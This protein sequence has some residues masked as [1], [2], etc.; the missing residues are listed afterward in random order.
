MV[1]RKAISSRV[2]LSAAIVVLLV[3]LV[4]LAVIFVRLQRPPLELRPDPG[5]MQWIR[6]LYG[7]GP[8]ADEQFHRP[9]SVAIGP[10][11]RIY[12]A[13]PARGRVMVFSPYGRFERMVYT[14][15]GGKGEGQLTQPEAID[16]DREGNLYIADSRGRKIIVFDSNGAF[17]REWRVDYQPR[18]V[19]VSASTVYVLGEGTVNVY[20]ATGAKIR[21][22][23]TRGPEPGQIDAY[24]GIEVDHNTVL[25]AD[26]FNRRIQAFDRS[27]KL[28]WARPE[29][30]K[31]R[32]IDATSG[33]GSSSFRWDLPQDLVVDGAGRL[34]VVDAFRYEIVVLDLETGDIIAT[35]GGFGREEGRFNHPTSIEYDPQRDW[36]AIADTD[37][38]RVQVVRIPGSGATPIAAVYR[39]V[40]SP[41]RWVVPTLVLLVAVLVTSLVQWLRTAR[42]GSVEQL[43]GADAGQI[44]HTQE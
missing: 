18:G 40:D 30:A 31:P 42:M 38:G 28:L 11:G 6:S 29:R 14:G 39:V 35:Y 4:F 5:G 21:R 16:V 1:Y 22:F 23:G 7:F 44:R 20:T 32:S 43:Y 41:I 19:A 17:V 26:A 9:Y 36:F 33:E 2:F 37:N 25:I 8:S 34:V 24:L 15:S 3:V 12:A 27:G 13:D 10:G